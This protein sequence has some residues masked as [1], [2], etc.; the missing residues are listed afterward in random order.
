M[1]I[2]VLTIL[3]LHLTSAALPTP[4]VLLT[5]NFSA[6]HCSSF[7]LLQSLSVGPFVMWQAVTRMRT[8]SSCEKAGSRECQWPQMRAKKIG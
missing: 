8:L 4:R 7:L 1:L 6:L 3:P 5:F 2:A